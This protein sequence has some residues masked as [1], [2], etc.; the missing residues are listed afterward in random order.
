MEFGKTEI[1]ELDTIDFSFPANPV[2]TKRYLRENQGSYTTKVYVGCSKWGQKEWIG[3]VYPEGTA[4]KD[5][6]E[7]YIDKYE[8]IELDTTFYNIQR[9]NV[10]KLV[11]AVEGKK[12][13]VC[14]KFSRRISHAKDF[15]ETKDLVSYFVDLMGRFEENL[16]SCILQLPE[17]FAQ[18]RMQDL[19][20]LLGL[21]PE[22]FPVNVE[23][24]NKGWFY[25]QD[26]P[27]F[28]MLREKKAG[29]AISATAG[30]RDAVHMQITN[31]V[32]IIRFVGNNQ[33]HTDYLR[34]D[35]W[36][37]RINDWLQY[38]ALKEI[39]FFVHHDDEKHSPATVGY[40]AEKLKD[41]C[42]V[43]V[44]APLLEKKA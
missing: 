34:M 30:R 5:F 4:E 33:H 7:M 26:H 19:R 44:K 25:E 13:K 9:K 14:P 17:Y 42:G 12:F 24:R 10:L 11:E 22:G 35:L 32:V 2:A 15:E 31:P 41:V 39:Y 18:K 21:L 1:N 29:V 27:V 8:C 28:D 43:D 20:N 37:E 6:L 36:A 3:D 38:Q 16:G 40:M 23:L